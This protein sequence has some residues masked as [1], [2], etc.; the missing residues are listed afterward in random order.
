MGK[1]SWK[2]KEKYNEKSYDRISIRIPKGKKAMLQD[3]SE[4]TGKSINQ[5]Y[6]DA[7]VN[8]YPEIFK[9]RQV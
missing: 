7:L 5:I 2:V 1:T 4:K 3:Y 9:E 6:N 8:T